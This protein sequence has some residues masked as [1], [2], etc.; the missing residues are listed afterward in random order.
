MGALNRGATFARP[1]STMNLTAARIMLFVAGFALWALTSALPMTEAVREGWD[2]PVYWQTRSPACLRC[3]NRGR[4]L[5]EGEDH[6]RAALGAARPYRRDA[7]HRSCRLGLRS[8]A[9]LGPVRRRAALS[10]AARRC[11]YRTNAPET[12]G[13]RVVIL[14]GDALI[15][16]LG[17]TSAFAVGQTTGRSGPWPRKQHHGNGGRQDAS[18]TNSSMASSR[19]DA[20]ARAA[21]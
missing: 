14:S 18:C 3:A 10:H 2:R 16:N 8:P 9:A 11:V 17:G 6:P 15:W 12:D 13:S 21:R 20:A 1:G 19:A 4:G 7:V 5:L